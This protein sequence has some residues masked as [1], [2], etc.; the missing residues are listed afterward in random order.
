MNNQLP[1]ALHIVGFL[2]ASEGM[3]LTSERMAS[4]YGTSPVLVRRVLGKLQ[5]AGLVRSR[6]GS[7]GGSVLERAPSKINLREVFEAVQE[8]KPVLPEY[9]DSCSGAVAPVLRNYLNELF[10][11]AEEA[12]LRKLQSITVAQMDR[13]VRRRILKAVRARAAG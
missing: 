3:P 8:E 7:K 9:S 11:E 1:I 4:V 6:R 2:A 10:A 13:S 12:M 5:S